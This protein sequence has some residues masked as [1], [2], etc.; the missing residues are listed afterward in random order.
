M[1]GYDDNKKNA[2]GSPLGAVAMV[3]DRGTATIHVPVNTHGGFRTPPPQHG[4][5]RLIR[6][7]EEMSHSNTVPHTICD[8]TK[9][10]PPLR[11]PPSTLRSRPG[12]SHPTFYSTHD[13][14]II[15]DVWIFNN[16]SFLLSLSSRIYTVRKNIDSSIP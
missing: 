2:S 14:R 11:S 9:S 13:P 5:K 8:K 1:F 10:T 4:S 3:C 6:A 16:G 15:K 12:L 7:G